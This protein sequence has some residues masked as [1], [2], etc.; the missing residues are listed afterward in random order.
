MFRILSDIH[1]GKGSVRIIPITR[2][3]IKQNS[4]GIYT[5][6]G[7]VQIYFYRIGFSDSVYLLSPNTG[8]LFSTNG[9]I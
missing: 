4:F 9:A 7:S 8:F 6:F 1:L 5:G 3:T 2:Y